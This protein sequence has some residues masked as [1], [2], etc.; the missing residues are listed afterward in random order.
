MNIIP[1]KGIRSGL[2]AK[3]EKGNK[4]KIK[5]IRTREKE[6]EINAIY[7]AVDLKYF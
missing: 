2:F 1:R 4:I 5:K 7:S 3:P 6:R